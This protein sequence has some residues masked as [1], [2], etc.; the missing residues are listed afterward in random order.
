MKH[1]PKIGLILIALTLLIGSI[2]FCEM[3]HFLFGLLMVAGIIIA[4]LYIGSLFEQI[5]TY[6]K[7][8]EAYK[9]A[10]EI[11]K[12]SLKTE[13][14]YMEKLNGFVS[15]TLEQ[16]EHMNGA[17]MELN[18][19]LQENLTVRR[20]DNLAILSGYKAIQSKIGRSMK[21]NARKR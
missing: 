12:D 17:Q 19:F 21:T 16:M 4:T 7:L 5:N 20:I 10:E 15:D 14:E 11:Y 3:G 2:A 9:G 6:E 8:T 1:L 18:E 13:R